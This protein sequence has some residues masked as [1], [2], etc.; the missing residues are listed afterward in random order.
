MCKD[1]YSALCC[2]MEWMNLTIAFWIL[3]FACTVSLNCQNT[4]QNACHGCEKNYNWTRSNFFYDGRK[5]LIC[6][7]DWHNVRSYLF[8]HVRTFQTVC[9]DLSFWIVYPQF[10]SF[11]LQHFLCFLCF[12]QLPQP[13]QALLSQVHCVSKFRICIAYFTD[14]SC[15]AN[16]PYAYEARD[17]Y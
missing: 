4:S 14:F 6:K 12:L 17:P 5:F 13:Q 3:A 7:L 2:E 15:K 8:F 11:K 16:H 1:F 9:N 10:H